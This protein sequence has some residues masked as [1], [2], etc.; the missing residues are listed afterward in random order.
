MGHGMSAPAAPNVDGPWD[1]G[2][3][4]IVCSRGARPDL[5]ASFWALYEESFGPL[6]IRAAARQ[7]LTEDE[8]SAELDDPTT[9]KYVALDSSGEPAGLATLTDD[10]ST[11]PWISPEYFAHRYPHESK[12]GAVFYIG[13]LLVRPDMRGHAVFA[14]T[15]TCMAERVTAARGVAAF[16]FC[17]YNDQDLRLGSATAK[18]LSRENAFEVSAVDVQTYYVARATGYEARIDS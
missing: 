7:V 1:F 3:F 18:I 14:R 10:V 12:R 6:R 17:G 16:D 11:M 8:F 9:W 2:T 5:K 15:V 13:V 4:S